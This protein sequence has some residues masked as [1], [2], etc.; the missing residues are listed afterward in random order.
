MQYVGGIKS[1]ESERGL[2]TVAYEVFVF[3]GVFL[4]SLVFLFRTP[5]PSISWSSFPLSGA[6]AVSVGQCSCSA[7][8]QRSDYVACVCA[9]SCSEFSCWLHHYF[10]HSLHCLQFF[11]LSWILWTEAGTSCTRRSSPHCSIPSFRQ[12]PERGAQAYQSNLDFCWRI[13]F[14]LPAFMGVLT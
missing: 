8:L 14:V 7:M 4:S 10:R 6:R 9:S 11:V 3:G 12:G 1:L 5:S 2:P 13:L